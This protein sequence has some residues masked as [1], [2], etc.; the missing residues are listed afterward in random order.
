VPVLIVEDDPPS[1]RLM[2]LVLE[3]VGAETRH[4]RTAEEALGML[5]TYS[6]QLLVTDVRLP[7]LDGLELVRTVKKTRALVAIAVTA[8]NGSKTA[9][10]AKSAGCDAFVHKPIDIDSFVQTVV[11]TVYPLELP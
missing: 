7:G 8:T 2:T 3:G 11:A 10:L 4:V 6:P 5:E 1:A 9:E